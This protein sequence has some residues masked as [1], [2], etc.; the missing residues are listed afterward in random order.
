MLIQLDGSYHRWLGAGRPPFTLLLAVDDATGS[1]VD[2]LF[3]EQEDSHNYFL[4]MQ[5]LLRRRLPSRFPGN[6][7]ELRG[8]EQLTAGG[9]WVETLHPPGAEE[10]SEGHLAVGAQLRAGAAADLAANDQMAQAALGGVVV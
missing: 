6:S 5:N 7:S 2:A 8:S 4:L 3:C 9:Q 10:G 1:L